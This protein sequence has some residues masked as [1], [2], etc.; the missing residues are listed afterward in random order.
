M[1]NTT[2]IRDEIYE[3]VYDYLD[4]H[5]VSTND[6]QDVYEWSNSVYTIV[7]VKTHSKKLYRFIYCNQE[8]KKEVSKKLTGSLFSC[9]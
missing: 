9:F 8:K 6:I 4:E 1:Y 5:R 7:F 3:Y 2:S